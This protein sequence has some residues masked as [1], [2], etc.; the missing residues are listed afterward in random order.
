[1]VGLVSYF[2]DLVQ[3][4]TQCV[5]PQTWIKTKSCFFESRPRVHGGQSKSNATISSTIIHI[6]DSR[7][8]DQPTRT[9]NIEPERAT[10]PYHGLRLQQSRTLQSSRLLNK[11]LSMGPVSSIHRRTTNPPPG[12]SRSAACCFVHAAEGVVEQQRFL[13]EPNNGL[14]TTTKPKAEEAHRAVTV[15]KRSR[16]CWVADHLL[17]SCLRREGTG[18]EVSVDLQARC[19]DWMISFLAEPAFYSVPRATSDQKQRPQDHE[20][21]G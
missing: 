17:H 9:P 12:G 19:R 11:P 21:T 20:R 13:V 5:S 10:N 3:R 16:R 14:T 18:D 1:M 7:S 2:L 15:S 4:K 8:L 6:T